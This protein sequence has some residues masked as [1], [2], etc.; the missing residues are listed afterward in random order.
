MLGMGWQAPT[1]ICSGLSHPGHRSVYDSG[2]PNAPLVASLPNYCL[3]IDL[4]EYV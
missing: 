3:V 4:V 1:L 2:F